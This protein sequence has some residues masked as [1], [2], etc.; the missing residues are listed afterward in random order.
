MGWNLALETGDVWLEMRPETEMMGLGMVAG[1]GRCD[2]GSHFR[3]C[4]YIFRVLASVSSPPCPT[5][6]KNSRINNNVRPS[7]VFES[8]TSIFGQPS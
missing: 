2:G 6:N 8:S 7:L 1:T 5:A 3:P 4:G